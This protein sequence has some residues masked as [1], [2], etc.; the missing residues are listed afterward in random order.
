MPQLDS[1]G[2]K[3]NPFN[4]NTAQRYFYAD[5]NR[6]QILEST[7]HLIEFSNNLQVVMGDPGVGKTHFMT[8][9]QARKD[10][11]CGQS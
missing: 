4:N 5:H 2:L 11:N 9:L 3:E 7:E 10:N 1:L 8:A 6:A